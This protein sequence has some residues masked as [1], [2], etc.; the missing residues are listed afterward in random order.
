MQ[1]SS[2]DDVAMPPPGKQNSKINKNYS[3]SALSSAA[4]AMPLSLFTKGYNEESLPLD[5][6][7]LTEAEETSTLR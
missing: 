1:A 3:G 2:M 6:H 4:Q 5:G 7:V